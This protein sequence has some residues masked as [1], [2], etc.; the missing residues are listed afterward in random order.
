MTFD[1][2]INEFIIIS[3]RWLVG[4]KQIQLEQQ[5]TQLP[6]IIL[7]KNLKLILWRIKKGT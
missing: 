7:G 1:V 5:N 3:V 2:E 4:L 6:L